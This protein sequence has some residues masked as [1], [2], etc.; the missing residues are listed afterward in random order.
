MT[1]SPEETREF[2]TNLGLSPDAPALVGPTPEALT[3]PV[4]VL[5]DCPVGWGHE[6][7]ESLDIMRAAVDTCLWPLFEVVDGRYTLTFTPAEKQPIDGWL[8][9]QKRFAH[10]LKPEGA[11]TLAA[12]QER[13]DA[14][15]AALVERCAAE[16]RESD[17][18]IAPRRVP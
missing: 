5:T 14:D 16:A 12:I 11:Y 3:T 10:L 1:K 2:L 13:V 6:P 15:W 8:R 4:N 18:T 7:R 9:P 17:E